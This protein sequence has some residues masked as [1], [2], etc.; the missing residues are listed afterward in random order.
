MRNRPSNNRLREWIRINTSG[1]F[2]DSQVPPGQF[3][4]RRE[5]RIDPDENLPLFN[6]STPTLHA[7][8][9]ETDLSME[10]L[11]TGD[12]GF[13]RGFVEQ[14]LRGVDT[15][16]AYDISITG[17]PRQLAFNNI[18]GSEGAFIVFGRDITMWFR[19][20]S[21]FKWVWNNVG[22]T[23]FGDYGKV[24]VQWAL[25]LPWTSSQALRGNPQSRIAEQMAYNGFG[26]DLDVTYKGNIPRAAWTD[27]DCKVVMYLL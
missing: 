5:L 9:H 18:H 26:G 12:E 3:W 1:E 4:I 21:V 16:Q 13:I 6:W 20:R 8:N 10:F 25:R 19:D 22:W 24:R 7:V 11:G 14:S 17:D 2:R 27:C 15:W 23:V